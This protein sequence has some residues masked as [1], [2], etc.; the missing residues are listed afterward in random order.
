MKNRYI[1]LM[2]FL[3]CLAGINHF[4]NPEFYKRIMPQWLPFHYQLIYISGAAE[5]LSGIL[6][7]P[8]STRRF[9]GVGLIVLLIAVF[10]ANI[11][12]AVD[13]AT[14]HHPQ[15]WI[16][17]LRLPLQGILVYWAYLATRPVSG[18]MEPVV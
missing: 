17:F 4:I 14:Q 6:L 5:V 8:L 12:M 2:A 1:Y 9:A 16:A 18:K 11:Q 15:W 7:L 10:P 3:Y 13:H